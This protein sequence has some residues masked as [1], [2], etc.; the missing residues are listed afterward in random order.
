MQTSV[1]YSATSIGKQPR[2]SPPLLAEHTLLRKSRRTMKQDKS[3]RFRMSAISEASQLPVKTAHAVM[4]K[5]MQN[6][7]KLDADA[8]FDVRAASPA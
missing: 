4:G 1:P 7:S 6:F 2:L 5:E 8:V 3:G